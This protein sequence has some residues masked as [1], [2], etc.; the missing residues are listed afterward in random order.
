MAE[1]P[2]PVFI[3]SGPTACGKSS[4]AHALATERGLE[5]VSADSI[6]IYRDLPVASAGPSEAEI[7]L[8]RYHLAACEPPETRFSAGRF[9]AEAL[10][11]VRRLAA[12]GRPALIVGGTGFYVR[13]LAEGIIEQGP[14][15]EETQRAL[16]ERLAREGP[17]ALHAEL[18]RVDPAAA[19]AIHPNN[20]FRTMRALGVWMET[21][22]PISLLWARQKA[23]PDPPPV[24][25]AL[26]YVI[27]R[28]RD[29]L[30]ARV[31]LRCRQMW[32]QG[33]VEEA[34]LLRESLLERRLAPE[35]VAAV[36][37][38]GIESIFRGL[39]S[40]ELKRYDRLPVDAPIPRR[41]A[42]YIE[43]MEGRTRR[44]AKRQL[45]WLKKY[46]ASARWLDATELGEAA[47]LETMRDDFAAW[48]R[49]HGED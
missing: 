36:R 19:A 46:A 49:R 41:L 8:F 3:I 39:A 22:E 43:A 44:Y 21:G 12:A 29:D 40:G 38:L 11:H 45:T 34:A 5:I 15:E 31:R 35:S 32:E 27:S 18:A 16:E 37:T 1:R 9:V 25:P 48:F 6:Q 23:D 14:L 33:V 2:P 10:P 24:L 17:D 20:A 28:R 26:Y 4:L 47:T 13:A 7:A 42:P 30:L